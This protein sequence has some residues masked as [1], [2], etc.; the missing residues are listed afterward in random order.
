[1]KKREAPVT[2]QTSK[3][4]KILIALKGKTRRTTKK[5]RTEF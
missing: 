2:H 5:R 3:K 1:L 4:I